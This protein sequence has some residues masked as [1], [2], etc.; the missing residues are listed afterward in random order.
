MAQKVAISRDFE[1]QLSHAAT[2]KL[3][4][5]SRGTQT[6]DR[7]ISRP[8]VNLLIYQDSCNYLIYI[9]LQIVFSGQ[10][11][12]NFSYFLTQTCR[13]PQIRILSPRRF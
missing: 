7:W 10:L 2:G 4:E 9:L 13:D 1:A 5:P 3:F 12:N 11:Y 6:R 8:A